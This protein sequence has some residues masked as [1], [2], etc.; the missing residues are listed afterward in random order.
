MTFEDLREKY[1]EL[2][3]HQ[4][5]PANY[6]CMHINKDGSSAL[7]ADMRSDRVKCSICGASFS[8]KRSKILN[9]YFDDMYSHMQNLF[10]HAKINMKEED[11][12]Y[13]ESLIEC[14][15]KFKEAVEGF[16]SITDK[17]KDDESDDY[18]Q[19]PPF[20]FSNVFQ[21]PYNMFKPTNQYA[22]TGAPNP[23][24]ENML[25]GYNP[26]YGFMNNNKLNIKACPYDT[27]KPEE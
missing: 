15:V 1:R 7:T 2:A 16:I 11:C 6:Y 24:M 13:V 12:F 5:I 4:A 3:E 17:F 19:A 20:E 25:N 14:M 9:S 22:T 26:S 27:E 10:N 21:Y 23:I 8:S 18:P